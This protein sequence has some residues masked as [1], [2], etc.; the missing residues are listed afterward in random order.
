MVIWYREFKFPLGVRQ[1]I[2]I[3]KIEEETN[4]FMCDYLEKTIEDVDIEKFISKEEFRGSNRIRCNDF[5]EI[6]KYL[7]MGNFLDFHM[8]IDCANIPD[9]V[10][11]N[12]SEEYIKN[13]NKE[14]PPHTETIKE[15]RRNMLTS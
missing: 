8:K 13:I 1:T 3:E 9:Y 15:I 10:C 5:S 7:L 12:S 2:N 6:Q 14:F 11:Y 4:L